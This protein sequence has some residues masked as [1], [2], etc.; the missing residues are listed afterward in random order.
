MFALTSVPMLT[1]LSN[2]NTLFFEKILFHVTTQSTS[3]HIMFSTKSIHLSGG[4][5]YRMR[6]FVSG[7]STS[8]G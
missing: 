2:S 4:L 7:T 5:I 1:V 8:T 6:R 3:D